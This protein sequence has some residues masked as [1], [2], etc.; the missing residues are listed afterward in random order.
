MR[1]L[2]IAALVAGCAASETT[3]APPAPPPTIATTDRAGN[4]LEPLAPCG[5]AL[6]TADGGWRIDASGAT[7]RGDGSVRSFGDEGQS[8]ENRG[9][10]PFVVF[11][12]GAPQHA[13]F[14][15]TTTT[16]EVYSGGSAEAT[17]LTLYEVVAH[18]RDADPLLGVRLSGSAMIRACFNEAD[19]R[20]RREACHDEYAYAATLN[21]DPGAATGHPRFLYAAEAASYPGRVS[22][23]EESTQAPALRGGDL[24]WARDEACSFRRTM[25]LSEEGNGYMPNEPMPDCSDYFT[26]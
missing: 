24:V 3:S 13:L 2:L 9:V 8:A 1:G 4:R 12:G 6:C 15:V 7:Y 14:G 22:R 17:V 19:M 10:W 26:Q 16:S 25:V 18:N 11:V 23:T 20:A 5:E 21:L